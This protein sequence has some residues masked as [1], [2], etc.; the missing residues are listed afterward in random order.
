MDF[1]LSEDQTILEDSLQRF[2]AAS[3]P[4]ER[5]RAIQEHPDGHDRELWKELARL[6]VV[7]ILVPDELGGSGLGLLDAV[8]AARVLGHGAVPGPF[9]STSVMAPVALLEGDEALAREWLPRIAAGEAVVGIAATEAVAR[10]DDV[11]LDVEKGSIHGTALFV[12]DSPIADTFLVAVDGNRLAFVPRDTRGLEVRKLET[13]D[14][15]RRV[16][17]LRFDGVEPAAWIGDDGGTSQ[18]ARRMIEAGRI[19]LG[20]DALGAADRALTMA[21]EYAKERKQFGRV[22]GSFQGLKHVLADLAAMLEPTRSLVWYAAHAFD[23]RSDDASLVAK[24]AKAH[25]A[26][27][28]MTVV[29]GA[30]EAHG[31]IGFTE[32][33]PLHLWFKRVML[34]RQL[35]GGPELLREEI[36][37]LEGWLPS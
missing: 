3:A 21:V 18:V 31:G 13:V 26:E 24:H 20:A 16:G 29:R 7:G 36:A 19:T 12:L 11:R 34:D 35:L 10:R 22:I 28:A 27:V 8:V 9:L 15:T 37:R 25:L 1:G 5:V 30:T 23:E 17:E 2:V 6:G 4:V 33:Y 14:L 32:E